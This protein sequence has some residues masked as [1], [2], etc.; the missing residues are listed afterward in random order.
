MRK[1]TFIGVDDW[2]RPVYR[3]EQGKLWKDVNL[4]NGTPYLHRA[5]GDDFEGE[6]DYPISGEYEIVKKMEV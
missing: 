2:S 5:V 4:G 3:D 6:P 1:L